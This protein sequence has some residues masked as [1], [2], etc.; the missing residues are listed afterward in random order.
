MKK[1]MLFYNSP[2]RKNG[3]GAGKFRTV[4]LQEE[5]ANEF[6]LLLQAYSEVCGQRV[7][8]TQVIERF[9]D[10]AVRQCDPDVFEVFSLKKKERVDESVV[11][12]DP[13][14][15]NVWERYYFFEKDGERVSAHISKEG[16]FAFRQ[17]KY[18]YIPLRQMLEDGYSLRNDLGVNVN[19]EQAEIIGRKIA[20]HKKKLLPECLDFEEES[21]KDKEF[22]EL[23]STIQWESY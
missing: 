10:V 13:T 17:S 6:K 11:H 23:L 2:R 19:T 3:E 4:N 14:D 22:N 12:I 5:V 1:Y 7:T 20:T 16:K 8:P 9:M 21:E 15:G 18:R